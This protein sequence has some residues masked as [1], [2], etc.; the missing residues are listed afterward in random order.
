[1]PAHY[2][3]EAPPTSTSSYLSA[4][5]PSD[6][7]PK[8]A[9]YHYHLPNEL[10]LEVCEY[11]SRSSLWPL[12]LT[13]T[14]FLAIARPFLYRQVKL[15]ISG[16]ETTNAKGAF[17]ALALLGRN[18]ELMHAVRKLDVRVLGTKLEQDFGIN[19]NTTT[20]MKNGANA[21]VPGLTV[22]FFR[23]LVNLGELH[24]KGPILVASEEV[25]D[26]V[27]RSVKGLGLR[28][29]TMDLDGGGE[30]FHEIPHFIGLQLRR[31]NFFAGPTISAP[32]LAFTNACSVDQAS[33]HV[34]LLSDVHLVQFVPPSLQALTLR[35]FDADFL[36]CLL[37]T[38]NQLDALQELTVTFK[39]REPTQP[40][41]DIQ[42]FCSPASPGSTLSR[43]TKETLPHL[44]ILALPVS[45]VL[46]LART[47]S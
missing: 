17:D 8:V 5:T 13:S 28:R 45:F 9:L 44:K 15:D 42:L 22:A 40:P 23:N 19:A 35:A 47:G 12:C 7:Q 6:T 37:A 46:A 26:E 21:M 14:A 36:P 27:R 10:W 3:S 2:H 38:F 25:R 16:E 32:V 33:G 39:P 24:M 1:M 41:V 20:N 29:L 11:L 34:P 43:L 18:E 4:T 30:S 31:R